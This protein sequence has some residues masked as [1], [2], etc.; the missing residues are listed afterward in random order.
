MSGKRIPILL[1]VAT[2]IPAIGFLVS[3]SIQSQLNSDLAAEGLP[4][5]QEICAV[6]ELL[7]NN[8]IAAACTEFS[9]IVLL[10]QAS[11]GAGVLGLFIPLVYLGGAAFAGTNRKRLASVFPPL[12]QISLFLLS[13]SVLAQGAILTYAAY[14]GEIYAIERVH[15]FIIGAIGLGA[16]VAAVKLIASSFNLRS[17]LETT[18]IGDILTKDNAHQIHL[19]VADI[20][21]KLKARAPDNIVIGLEPNFFATSASVKVFGK[22]KPLEGET[23]YV[24]AP[25]AR[26]LSKYELTAVIGHELGHFRGEDTVYTLKFAPVYAGLGKALDV[27][28]TADE[29]GA[30]GLAKLPALAMLSFMFDTFSRS[31]RQVGRERELMADKAGAEVSSR[32]A[33]ASALLKITLY[34]SLWEQV[35][36]DNIERLTSGKITG[37]LS[38]VFENTAKYDVEHHTIDEIIADVSERTIEHPTDTH[39]PLKKRVESLGLSVSDFTKDSLSV[40]SDNAITLFEEAEVIERRLTLLEH[41]LMVALGA[42]HLPDEEEAQVNYILR[43]SYMLVAAMVAADG[44]ILP[45]EIKLAERIGCQLFDDFDTVEFREYCDH[46]EDLPEADEVVEI[47]NDVLSSEQKEEIF[48]YLSAITEADSDLSIEEATLLR[49]VASGFGLEKIHHDRE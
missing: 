16:F 10:G 2:G 48:N 39:P 24:S 23:L 32:E 7:E 18:V 9:N 36:K 34:S 22:D 47:L 33:L 38:K 14:I 5:Y 1:L 20:A 30:S 28:R 49:K 31:E 4:S 25:L 15:Y 37:N 12:V 3:Y 6:S 13:V 44:R 41:K 26:L 8:E 21:N 40:P 17:K 43:A 29:E 27:M 45:E 19:F 42:V 35:R 46:H 11:V